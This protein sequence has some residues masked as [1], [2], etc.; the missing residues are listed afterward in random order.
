[1]DGHS[2]RTERA[3]TLVVCIVLILATCAGYRLGTQEQSV[4]AES[5]VLSDAAEDRQPEEGLF[6]DK[7]AETT[8]VGPDF[9][10]AY[11]KALRAYRA[12]LLNQ[13]SIANGAYFGQIFMVK[14][15]KFAL[16]DMND[17]GIP[18]LHVRGGG[19]YCVFGYAD[20]KI[21]LWAKFGPDTLLL[22][23]RAFYTHD[24]QNGNTYEYNEPDFHNIG[25]GYAAIHKFKFRYSD[26][27]GKH[28]YGM[29]RG[30]ILENWKTVSKDAYEIFQPNPLHTS[31]PPANLP[32]QIF[33]N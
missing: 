6:A 21:T 5:K 29:G 8:R 32:V 10:N 9:E 28:S 3:K 17:D 22:N 15:P 25:K 26:Y 31:G 30:G 1:M 11:F 23:N 4:A 20:G 2:I 33:S 18:E 19:G 24:W 12:Y 16:I 14:P 7:V 13:R 27:A